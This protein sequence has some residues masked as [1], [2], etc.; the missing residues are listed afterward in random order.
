MVVLKTL[1][2]SRYWYTF[3]ELVSSFSAILLLS[4]S[5][6]AEVPEYGRLV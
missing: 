1:Y 2:L 5:K 4:S 3:G 6:I